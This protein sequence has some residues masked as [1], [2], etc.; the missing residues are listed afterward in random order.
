VIF[1]RLAGSIGLS[2]EQ[3]IVPYLLIGNFCF[4]RFGNTPLNRS[5]YLSWTK[6]DL[7]CYL[8]KFMVSFI[9]CNMSKVALHD[10]ARVLFVVI[11]DNNLLDLFVLGGG[12][13]GIY[14]RWT[15]IWD[16]FGGLG[17]KIFLAQSYLGMTQGWRALVEGRWYLRVIVPSIVFDQYGHLGKCHTLCFFYRP[18]TLGPGGAPPCVGP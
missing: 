4:Q 3:S 8:V 15:L 11:V 12:P 16:S 18:Y 2:K 5:K 6:I 1:D 17:V 9:S 14:C 7:P 10:I 13:R